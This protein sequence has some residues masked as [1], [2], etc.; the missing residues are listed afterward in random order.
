MIK[1]VSA[2]QMK[3]L[4]ALA[5]KRFGIPALILM[6]NAGSAASE[7]V[8][9]MLPRKSTRPVAI[10]C[11]YGNNGGDGFVCARHLINKG[12]KV[13]VYLVGKE[14]KFS[15]DAK[16]NYN[17]LCKMKQKFKFIKTVGE[18]DK[19]KKEINKCRLII[20]GIFGIG[21]NGEL[22]AFYQ[23]LFKM[24]NSSKIAILALDV[25]SGLNADTGKPLGSAIKASRTVTFGFVKKGLI[26]KEASKFTGKIIIANIS[27][28]R[29]S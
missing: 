20:D 25:P 21:L 4:D 11:G 6:E 7:E 15:E 27:L 2:S 16:I 22:D 28:P 18:L 19:I 8:L 5:V 24:L 26:K 10:F 1:I 12:I 17:I 13:W 29:M 9:K 3:R 14:K 23:E